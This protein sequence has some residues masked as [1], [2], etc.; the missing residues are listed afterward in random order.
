MLYFFVEG[1]DDEQYFTKIIAPFA[2]TYQVVRYANM[3]NRKINNFL[4]TIEQ[5]PDCD[6][7]FFGDADRKSI[8]EQK[9]CLLKK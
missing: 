5:M 3:Q 8:E 1:P 2:G 9:A 7:L 4:R 6:Y